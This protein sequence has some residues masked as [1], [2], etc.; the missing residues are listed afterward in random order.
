MGFGESVRRC[1]RGWIT[2]TGR[3]SRA[4]YWW[5][6][7]FQILVAIAF[8]GAFFAMG[9]GAVLLNASSI[10]GGVLMGGLGVVF[11]LVMLYLFVASISVTIRRLHD[12]NMS[13]W[14][15]GGFIGLNVVQGVVTGIDG[16]GGGALGMGLSVLVLVGSLALFVL[17]VLRGTPGPNRY[18]P[19]PHMPTPAEIFA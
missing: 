16:T 15:Y 3:A 19:D 14:W 17:M 7:L 1:L 9:G 5:F 18:G 2:F 10:L 11:L 12:R 4:E 6:I 13:G 8:M